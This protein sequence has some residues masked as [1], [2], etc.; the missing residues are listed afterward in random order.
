MALRRGLGALADRLRVGDVVVFPLAR[1]YG[2]EFA[3]RGFLGHPPAQRV[4]TGQP[5]SVRASGS[6]EETVPSAFSS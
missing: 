6:S 5:T 2:W 3:V 4:T 1:A